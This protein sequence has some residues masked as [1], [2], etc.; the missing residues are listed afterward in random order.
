MHEDRPAKD[1]PHHII[2]DL[3]EYGGLSP[4]GQ[5]IWRLVLAQNCRT[6]CWGRMNHLAAGTEK[7]ITDDS[8]PTDIVPDR[9]SEGEHWIPKYKFTGWILQRWY[10]GSHWG[11]RQN[12]EGERAQDGRT[13]LLAA[14]PQ[15]GDYM[16]MPCGPWRSIAEVGDLHAAIRCYNA[17]QRA[18]P[19]N[20]ENHIQAWVA[21]DGIKRQEDADAFA[22][23]SEAVVRMSVSSV[24][25]TVSGAAQGVRN[26]VAKGVGGVNLGAAELWG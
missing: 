16:M 18:N 2:D 20:W 26:Q 12:W 23:E 13:R 1:T 25:R 21:L 9:I 6:R 8:R 4:D 5:P 7:R 19:V 17:Q 24:M 14:F 22:L 11:T 3:R 10:P 15:H